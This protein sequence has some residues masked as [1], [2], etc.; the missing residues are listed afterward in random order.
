MNYKPAVAL[1]PADSRKTEEFIKICDKINTMGGQASLFNMQF[2]SDIHEQ[3]MIDKFKKAAEEEY[4]E[5]EKNFDNIAAAA[6]T[7]E[8]AD[9]ITLMNELQRVYKMYGKAQQHDHFETGKKNDADKALSK[10]VE[11]IKHS[12]GDISAQIAKMID[13]M[14]P[15][16]KDTKEQ[17]EQKEKDI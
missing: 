10:A 1:L 14:K 17:K 9:K 3:E 8:D 4:A 15:P 7:D 11:A 6:D 5:I 2:V 16:Q 13:H 12:A